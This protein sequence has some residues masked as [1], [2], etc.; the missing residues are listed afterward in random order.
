MT[1]C[2][3]ER[4]GREHG[5]FFTAPELMQREFPE[6]RWAVP[7]L[8]AEGLTLLVGAPKFGKSW[9]CL[10]LA[11]AVAAGGKAL[12]KI[13]VESGA[14]L[15][16]AL[17]D[18]ARRLQN[19]LDIVM[20]GEAVPVG[21]D[22]VTVLPRMPKATEVIGGWL[23]AHPDARLVI[24]DVLRKVRPLSDGRT[25]RAAYDEDYDTLGALKALADQFSIAIVVVHHTRKAMDEADVINEVSG[26]TGLTGAADA[27]LIAK[28]ARNTSEAV[29]HVTGRDITEQEFG[30][31]WSA[32]GCQ[33]SLQDEPV[34]IASMSAT[35]RIIYDYLT[36][37]PGSTP[38]EITAALGISLNTVKQ[39]VRRMVKDDQLD[40]DG[41]GR[42]LAVSVTPVTA[43][44]QAIGDTDGDREGDSTR[45]AFALVRGLGDTGDTG[46]TTLTTGLEHG[47]TLGDSGDTEAC[48]EQ[49]SP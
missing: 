43:V 40:S 15:Y 49:P 9:I 4:V 10:N 28:R 30:L 38:K 36:D 23:D 37:H 48:C 44:T 11:V 17:E 12:G 8:I 34:V 39:T 26:S 2:E 19:R 45:P 5:F 33:W 22:F 47:D 42:Y 41:E 20:Q 29:L 6:P 35:R 1:V 32:Q 24:V 27:I 14:V 13:D 31:S 25:G 18:P 46:D 16:A 7:G 21:L 3:L